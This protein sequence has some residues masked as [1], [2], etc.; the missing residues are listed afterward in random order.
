HAETDA[1]RLPGA[2]AFTGRS[3]RNT[4]LSLA[5]YDVSK[6]IGTPT[7][8]NVACWDEEDWSS[9]SDHDTAGFWEPAMPHWLH[10]SP[11]ICH[12]METLLRHRPAY[13]NVVTANAV[14]TLAHELMHATGI[15]NEAKAECFGMQLTG[16]LAE[17][18]G[19]PEHYALR[20]SQLTLQN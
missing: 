2:S 1:P 16:E 12:S 4:R 11:S 13:P 7:M 10:L 9:F 8:V 3:I 14:E 18:L 19:V 20:L 5:A 15:E 6:L 17:R